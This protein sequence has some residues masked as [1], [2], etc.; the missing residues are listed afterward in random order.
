MGLDIYAGTLTRYYARNWKTTTQQWA[1]ANGFSFSRITPQGQ[2]ADQ[3]PD[4]DPQEIKKAMENWQSQI[5][6]A[7][8]S[9]DRPPYAPWTEDNETPYYTDKPDWDAF[10]ALLLYTAARTYQ[11]LLPPTVEKN[12][13]FE[14]HPLIKRMGEDEEKFWSLFIGASWWLPIE[15]GLAFNAPCPTDEEITF[16]T[17]GA[18]QMELN[19]IN[20]IGW[21]ADEA[22]I[23]SWARTEGYPADGEIKDGKL[24]EDGIAE[25]TIYDTESLA[26][27][28]YS[29]LWQAAKFSMEKRVPILL[30]F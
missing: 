1:E 29:I 10:G 27:F 6:A 25:H 22:T 8:S 11:E 19:H 13:D 5:L 23:V 3:E 4:P 12:W 2:N 24:T 15:D 18:L 16:S 26:K 9:K 30:D 7:I 21:Q 17:T 20:D 14:N 28:A